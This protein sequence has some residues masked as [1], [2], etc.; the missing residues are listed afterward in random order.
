[1]VKS[2]KNTPVI[3]L[4]FFLL[5]IGNVNAHGLETGTFG[6]Q[7]V[8]KEVN[9]IKCDIQSESEML[10]DCTITIKNDDGTSLEVTFH[11]I[12]W[13]QCAKIKVGKWLKDV[14]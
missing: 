13:Y 7:E 3:I 5:L 9:L 1:M 11:D 4:A 10:V 2:Y 12:S 14:F 6:Y 8:N